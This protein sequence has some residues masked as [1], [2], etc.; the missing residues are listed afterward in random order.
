VKSKDFNIIVLYKMSN[1][2]DILKLPHMGNYVRVANGL[3]RDDVDPSDQGDRMI[4]DV[5]IKRNV[6]RELNKLKKG[7]Q[8]RQIADIITAGYIAEKEE[9]KAKDK[10]FQSKFTGPAKDLIQV[11]DINQNVDIQGNIKKRISPDEELK[12]NFLVKKFVEKLG[13]SNFIP[14][15]REQSKMKAD[16]LKK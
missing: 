2:K 12:T 5:S 11:P 9:Q 10:Q 14:S 1:E 7:G 13:L 8:D 16:E 15:P 3:N 4:F 6:S